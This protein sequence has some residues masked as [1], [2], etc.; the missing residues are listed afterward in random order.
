MSRYYKSFMQT[1]LIVVV[2]IILIIVLCFSSQNCMYTS[3]DYVHTSTTTTLLSLLL[4]LPLLLVAVVV[5]LLDYFKKYH[6]F[7][8]SHYFYIEIVFIPILYDGFK[9]HMQVEVRNFSSDLSRQPM[10]TCRY[11][12]DGYYLHDR[13]D[14]T[15]Q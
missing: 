9:Y 15:L 3:I 7:Y 11:Y 14:H 5:V 13:V 1:T 6:L 12:G 4:Q 2:V 8:F 10:H